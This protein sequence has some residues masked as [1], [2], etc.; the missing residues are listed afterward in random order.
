MI[1]F[2]V[3][4]HIHA[5][6]A[7]Y[8]LCLWFCLLFTAWQNLPFFQIH[9]K[10]KTELSFRPLFAPSGSPNTFY[11]CLL[12]S[13]LHRSVATGF[14]VCFC[15]G[16]RALSC[17]IL[18]GFF[19]CLRWC[20]APKRHVIYLMDNVIFIHLLKRLQHFSYKSSFRTDPKRKRSWEIDVLQ[21]LFT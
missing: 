3:A 2:S 5:F 8:F 17:P 21:I 12:K 18:V 19:Q 6:A 15:H 13:F 20:L 1:T 9:S 7:C 4:Y 14:N 16:D 11:R 10:F